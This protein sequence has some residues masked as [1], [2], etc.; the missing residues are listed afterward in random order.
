[1]WGATSDGVCTKEPS[2]LTV[3]D[4]DA[5][6]AIVFYVL[7]ATQPSKKARSTPHRPT[8]TPPNTYLAALTMTCPPQGSCAAMQRE[9]ERG[10]G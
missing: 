1:M 10:K 2:V 3:G 8:L 6:I 5:A 9:P 7:Q 4:C